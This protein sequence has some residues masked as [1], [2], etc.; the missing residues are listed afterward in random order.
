MTENC[1]L[2][3]R[4]MVFCYYI[5][6]NW[7]EQSRIGNMTTRLIATI[8]TFNRSIGQNHTADSPNVIYGILILEAKLSCFLIHG[9]AITWFHHTT[10]GKSHQ[11]KTKYNKVV[12][13][14]YGSNCALPRQRIA[15]CLIFH[16]ELFQLEIKRST[17][18]HY[19]EH[20][21]YSKLDA[22]TKKQNMTKY[23]MIAPVVYNG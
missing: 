21:L 12:R 8:N 13:M 3:Y 20:L 15:F 18:V 2:F 7:L 14:F 10:S 19:P 1:E 22:I 9:N 4:G 16:K 11:N 17:E 6:F 23:D 5:L